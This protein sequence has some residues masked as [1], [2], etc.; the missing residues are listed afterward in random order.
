MSYILDALNRSEEKRNAQRHADS[1]ISAK[2]TH[3]HPG[4]GKPWLM[5]LLAALLLSGGLI[6]SRLMSADEQQPAIAIPPAVAPHTPASSPVTG[7]TKTPAKSSDKN[8]WPRK[9][10]GPAAVAAAPVPAA[11]TPLIQYTDKEAEQLPAAEVSQDVEA[12][13]PQEGDTYANIPDRSRLSAAQ[14]AALPPIQIEG[15]IYDKTPA[16]RMVIINNQL[17]REGQ[18]C[19]NGLTLEEITPD[20]V[21]LSHNG[22]AFHLGI[23]DR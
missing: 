13:P 8:K 20:G 18:S 6:L 19:G 16:A 17:L 10:L 9:Q 3:P 22:T 21:I 14:Q 23:F 7:A 4:R 5:M 1:G 15:H 11:D 12:S 2:S